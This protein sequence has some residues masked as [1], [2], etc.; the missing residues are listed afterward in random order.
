MWDPIKCIHQNSIIKNYLVYYHKKSLRVS[1]NVSAYVTTA[2]IH[3][4]D[5]NTEYSFEVLAVN[6]D[7]QTSPENT[8]NISTS[9]PNGITHFISVKL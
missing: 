4:L 7:N 3:E 1:V 8:L 2:T 6:E 9:I 5:T